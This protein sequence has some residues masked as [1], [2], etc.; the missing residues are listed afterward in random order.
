M[1]LQ[2]L[3]IAN[4]PPSI[5]VSAPAQVGCFVAGTMILTAE[6]EKAV[7]ALREGDVL[8]TASGECVPLVWLGRRTIDTAKAANRLQLLPVRIKAGAFAEGMPSRDLFVSADHAMFLDGV[9]V[10]AMKLINGG[11]IAQV[12]VDEVTYFHVECERHVVLVANGA[13]AE[14]YLEAENRSFFSNAPGAVD[15]QPTLTIP[16]RRARLAAPWAGREQ[17]TAIRQSNL[18]RCEALGY[19]IRTDA[20][21]EEDARRPQ[22]VA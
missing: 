22:R 9:L 17:I 5:P 7:E 13:A 6:G 12:E 2:L 4:I 11:T 19:L 20:T 3:P 18:K 10:P 14:S 8:V 15:L 21:A 1:V 16:E